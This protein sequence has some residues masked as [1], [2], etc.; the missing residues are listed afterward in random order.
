LAIACV[1]FWTNQHS[2][3]TVDNGAVPNCFQPLDLD[4]AYSV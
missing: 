1:E 2:R 4:L 3:S